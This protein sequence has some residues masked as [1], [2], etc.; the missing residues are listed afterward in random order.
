[1]KTCLTLSCKM[2]LFQLSSLTTLLVSLSRVSTCVVCQTKPGV[3]MCGSR[4]VFPPL[5]RGRRHSQPQRARTQAESFSARHSAAAC[6]RPRPAQLQVCVVAPG[7]DAEVFQQGAQWAASC[8]RSVAEMK[9]NG[10]FFF[11]I[12]NF[13]GFFPNTK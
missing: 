2:R 9:T 3:A 11:L 6:S 8:N 4:A 12:F 13:W 7:V 10:F 5:P 1:M